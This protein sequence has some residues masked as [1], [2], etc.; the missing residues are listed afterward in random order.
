MSNIFVELTDVF[1]EVIHLLLPL[2]GGAAGQELL[3]LPWIFIAV[4]K[5]THLLLAGKEVQV[6]LEQAFLG[7]VKDGQTDGLQL[8]PISQS[9][10][11][12]SE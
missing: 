7:V 8:G 3:V 11:D 10:Y 5:F 6:A 4:H 12:C 1:A 2:N 9:A